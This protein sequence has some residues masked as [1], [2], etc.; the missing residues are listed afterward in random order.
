MFCPKWCRSPKNKQ[1]FVQN[2]VDS[3]RISN[4]WP[5]YLTLGPKF[6]NF[7]VLSPRICFCFV[8]PKFRKIP[9]AL[10]EYFA[11][12]VSNRDLK[13]FWNFLWKIACDLGFAS[14]LK[15]KIS[16][17]WIEVKLLKLYFV[18]RPWL[19]QQRIKKLN[20]KMA[21]KKFKQQFDSF[22]R[23]RESRPDGP[24]SLLIN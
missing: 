17:V 5:K 13:P 24:S 2:D 20:Q 11:M 1:C 14:Y 19:H 16:K 10:D 7:S 21:S 9:A 22:Q 15:F 18:V 3:Q 6:Y 4:V 12:A 8:N 23:E